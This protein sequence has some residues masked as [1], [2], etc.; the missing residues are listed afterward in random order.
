MFVIGVFHNRYK[1]ISVNNHYPVFK[2][3]NIKDLTILIKVLIKHLLK[4]IIVMINYNELDMSPRMKI[5]GDKNIQNISNNS[6][7][8]QNKKKNFLW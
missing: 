5:W 6:I 3:N 4:Q 2:V 8:E 1:N 7:K